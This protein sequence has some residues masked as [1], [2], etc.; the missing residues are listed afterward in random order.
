MNKRRRNILIVVGGLVLL[1]I[2]AV[3]A[4]KSRHSDAATVAEQTVKYTAFTTKLPENGVVQRPR[5]QTI[6][7]EISGNLENIYVHAGDHVTGGQLLAT[8]SNP[9]IVST[10]NGSADS[11]RSAVAHAQSAALAA[12]ASLLTARERLTQAQADLA[13]GSQSGLGYGGGS[14]ADQRAQAEATLSNAQTNLSDAQR[15]YNANRDLYTSKAIS[16][17]ALQQS[18]VKYDLAKTAYDQAARALRSLGGQQQREQ[19][20]LREN[21]QSA[22]QAY[23]Q[24]QSAADAT[25][26]QA[27][28][29][30]AGSDYQ[31]AAEQAA[32]T[33]IRAPFSGTL[34]SVAAQAADALRP[35]QPGDSVSVGQT[36]FTLAADDAFIV[37]TKVDEQDIINVRQGQRA[38]ITGEDFPGKTLFGHV[39]AISPIAQ[40][41]DDPSSTARQIITTIRLD[42]S[43]A[44]LRDGM[45]VD[46]DILTTNIARAVVVPNDAVMKDGAKRFVYVIQKGTA[47]KQ[48]VRTGL[49]ND[50]QTVISGGLRPG[51][52]IVAE[53]P[54]TIADGASVAAAPSPSPSQ[55]P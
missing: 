52:V 16:L 46:V 2:V 53:K 54:V 20:V 24:A 43:P 28:A 40:K 33:Q 7:T 10:A 50:A 48:P 15:T 55:S 39:M 9:Q 22:Q 1:I 11:Y 32:R 44:F 31:F 8:I 36:I 12:R 14:A 34:L 19:G 25:A 21:L 18:K 35:I 23:Q 4:G 3:V 47:H 17:D 38:Q 27:D 49:S 6:A 42:S 51:D 29:A 5:T 37:R 30:R 26:A 41:S 45:S 13:N